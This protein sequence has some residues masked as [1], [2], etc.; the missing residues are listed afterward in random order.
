MEVDNEAHVTP[1]L[2][3]QL[4]KETLWTFQC[5][6]ILKR[7]GQIHGGPCKISLNSWHSLRQVGSSCESYPVTLRLNKSITFYDAAH[8]GGSLSLGRDR[9]SWPLKVISKFSTLVQECKLSGCNL[10]IK[11]MQDTTELRE[12]ILTGHLNNLKLPCP[13]RGASCYFLLHSSN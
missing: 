11:V 1:S 3:I 5:N 13:I 7:S 2:V 8:I 12:H 9:E 10:V 6:W 4:A